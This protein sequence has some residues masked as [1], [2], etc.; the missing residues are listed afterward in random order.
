M[1][2]EAQIVMHALFEC[3]GRQQVV[4]EGLIGDLMWGFAQTGIPDKAT[5]IGLCDLHKLGY[6]KFQAPDNTFVSADSDLIG[7][8]WVRYQPKLLEMVYEPTV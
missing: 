7:K 3:F 8:A 2:P 6:V 1:T 4:Q 5:W